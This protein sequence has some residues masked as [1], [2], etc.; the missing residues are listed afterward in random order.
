PPLTLFPY[1]TLFRS[2]PIRIDG[3]PERHRPGVQPVHEARSSKLPVFN[4]T[5]LVERRPHPIPH[6][7]RRDP[8]LDLHSRHLLSISHQEKGPDRKSTRLNS[9]HVS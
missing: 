6:S 9:S 3:P 4:A 5:T 2:A 7:R 8:W 1:T